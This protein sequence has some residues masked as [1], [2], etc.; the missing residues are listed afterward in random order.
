MFLSFKDIY[1]AIFRKR[2]CIEIIV[3]LLIEQFNIKHGFVK[4]FLLN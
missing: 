1:K 3:F 2:L 4:S